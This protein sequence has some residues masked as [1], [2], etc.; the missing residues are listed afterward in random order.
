MLNIIQDLY[1]RKGIFSNEG[2]KKLAFNIIKKFYE[3]K[4]EKPLLR[5]NIRKEFFFCFS[6]FIIKI[7]LSI[8]LSS[9]KIE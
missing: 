2:E 5:K 3:K 6:L 4:K 8:F 9:K 7:S 1:N